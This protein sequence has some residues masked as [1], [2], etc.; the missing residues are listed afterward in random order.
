MNFISADSVNV[1]VSHIG[2]TFAERKQNG[3]LIEKCS[4]GAMGTNLELSP[5]KCVSDTHCPI[6]ALYEEKD[7]QIRPELNMPPM[8]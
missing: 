8:R 1:T 6:F 5:A 2:L 4:H 7:I 3:T